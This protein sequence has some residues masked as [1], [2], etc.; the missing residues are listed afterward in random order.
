MSATTKSPAYIKVKV[1]EEERCRFTSAHGRRCANPHN[2]ADH[3]FCVV[4][5]RQ[6]E[7]RDDAKARA[8][9]AQ[10]L[11]GGSNLH[12]RQEVGRAMAQLFIL[13]SQKRISR[14]D[15]VLL[16]YIAS[17]LLQTMIPVSDKPT[18]EEHQAFVRNFLKDMPRPARER[19]PDEE[20]PNAQDQAES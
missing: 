14:R 4:H 7:K 3:K 5:E 8:V 16:A 12:N 10:L 11:S 2:G 20:T 15:G 13:I 18:P 9:S 1:P 17:L 19:Y 6:I